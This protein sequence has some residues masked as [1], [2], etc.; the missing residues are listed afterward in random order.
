MKTVIALLEEHIE[1]MAAYGLTQDQIEDAKMSFNL[2]QDKR[3]KPRSFQYDSQ[4]NN[5]SLEDLMSETTLLL[6]KL[7]GVMKRFRRSN[8]TFYA[9][10]EAARTIVEEE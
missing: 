6:T 8:A 3:Q 5:H 4:D 2:F 1:E 7:D 9:G 10:Y